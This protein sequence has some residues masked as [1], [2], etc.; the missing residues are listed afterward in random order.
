MAEFIKDQITE[1]KKSI[2][3]TFEVIGFHLY[4]DAPDDVNFLRHKHR[5]KF[6]IKVFCTVNH[7]NRALEFFQMQKILKSYLHR[8]YHNRDADACIFESMSCE[9]IAEDI[10]SAHRTA[11]QA[12]RVEVWED[13]ENGG[14]AQL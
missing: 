10:L 3:I 5:H 9:M 1:I 14:I 6:V 11:Y 2:A 8:K 12:Y 4:P 13:G 7:S